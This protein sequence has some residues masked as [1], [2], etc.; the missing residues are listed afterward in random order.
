MIR[1]RHK[2]HYGGRDMPRKGENIYKR[3]DGR[4]EGRYIRCYD[5]AGKAKYGYIYGRTY[6]GVKDTLVQKKA[7]AIH[8]PTA[9][10]QRAVAYGDILDG[11]LRA[12]K[13][14][15]K[16]S[17]YVRYAQLIMTHIKPYLGSYQLSRISTQQIEGF[18]TYL[19]SDGRLD[20]TGGLSPKTVTDILTIIKSTMEYARYQNMPVACN[21]HQLTVKKKGKEMRVLTPS[22]QESLV[23]VVTSNMDR[24]KFGV[25]LSLYTGI[26]LGELCAL[27]W[28]DF[29]A[30]LS[31]L[32]VRKTMQR[33][34]NMDAAS[35]S[36]TR[37][38]ITE[39]KSQCSIREIPLPPFLAEIAQSFQADPDAFVL[40]GTAQR[41]VEPRTMQNRFQSYVKQSGIAATNY[42][43][44][45]H[46]FA[47][48][49]VE[50]SFDIKT[51]SIILGHSSVN[52]TLNRYVHSSME[53]KK[54]NMS[55]LALRV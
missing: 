30:S 37:I 40:S 50:L 14:K 12:S 53:L 38:I 43:A 9:S 17:T 10:N 34:K 1:Q 4:W 55:K 16:E 54:A 48:R 26:R 2:N 45:R 44:L 36:K 7:D 35:G 19:L 31:T 22:E 6:T 52:I 20:G 27:Q 5:A 42:H 39:P 25:L 23:A 28:G 49:C 46:S 18:V 3:K 21:I 41:Y 11:W 32:M 15:T 24:Y 47:T 8:H 29:D 13:L 51:L 33:V